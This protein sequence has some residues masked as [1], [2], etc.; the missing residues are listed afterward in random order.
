MKNT[1]KTIVTGS[2]IAGTI[3]GTVSMNAAET[4]MFKYSE[5]GSGSV[6]RANLLNQ[7]ETDFKAYLLELNCGENTKKATE[8][9]KTEDKSKE[10]KCGEGKCGEG[11]EVKA[12][13][14]K[15]TDVKATE[16]KATDAKSTVAKD[17]TATKESKSKE[18]K[19]GE[20]KCGVE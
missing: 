1:K 18:A 6:I 3:M 17:T 7:T 20:G 19:C 13:D 4:S 15:A 8:T 9:K 12:K 11:K 5:L 16:V 10:A 14:A 2:L